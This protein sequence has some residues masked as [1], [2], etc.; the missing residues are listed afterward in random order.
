M[1]TLW[2]R[3]ALLAVAAAACLP[4]MQGCAALTDRE[5]EFRDGEG[6]RTG[7]I[8]EKPS[9]LDTAGQGAGTYALVQFGRVLGGWIR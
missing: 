5:L 8:V 2:T 6:R 4:A 1:K 9:L 7:S 3:K